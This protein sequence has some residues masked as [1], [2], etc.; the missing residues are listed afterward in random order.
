MLSDAATNPPSA[1]PRARVEGAQALLR[2]RLLAAQQV[3]AM[4]I[5]TW[6]EARLRAYH[7]VLFPNQ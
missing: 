5:G 4:L 3:E 2:A 6:A 1:I 7:R